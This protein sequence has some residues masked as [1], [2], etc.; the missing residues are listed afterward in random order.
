MNMSDKIV[1]LFPTK[2]AVVI[3]SPATMIGRMNS[4]LVHADRAVLV[5]IK[6]VG[7]VWEVNFQVAN[8]NNTETSLCMDI[9]KGT[10]MDS[11]LG[12]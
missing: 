12:K 9:V 5:L 3:E 11:I 8:M 2:S 1:N 6:D 4:E 7:G 10:I